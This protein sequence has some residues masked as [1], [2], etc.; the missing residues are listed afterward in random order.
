MNSEIGMQK[1]TGMGQMDG[2]RIR[3]AQLPY[4]ARRNTVVSLLRAGL[5]TDE[6]NDILICAFP[7]QTQWHYAD[8]RGC[9]R[10]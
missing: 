3:T 1:E 10:R 7:C 6:W 4:I 5:R 2:A 8:I 9:L